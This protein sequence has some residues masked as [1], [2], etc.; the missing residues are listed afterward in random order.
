MINL[1]KTQELIVDRLAS[2][3]AYLKSTKDNDDESVLL[4]MKEVEEGVEIGDKIKVFV[5]RDSKDRIIAT[6]KKPKLT[7]GDIGLLEVVD[8]TNIG[9]FMDWGLEKD[10]FIPFKEQRGKIKKGREYLVGTYIDKS[11]R[12][13]ATMNVYDMLDTNSP[14]KEDD[15]VEGMV[16]NINP[17]IGIFVAV[18][19]KYHGLIPKQRLFRSFEL[20][21]KIEAKVIKVRKDGKL[22]LTIRKK[23]YKQI[24][25][26]ADRILSKLKSNDGVLMI[27]DKSAPGKIQRELKMSKASFK[28]AVGKLL[29]ENKIKFIEGGIKRL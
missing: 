10:L 20:G 8:T 5:Y 15:K 18:D 23:A 11:D 7:L 1:G 13:C 19:N 17:E 3:G 21:E 27:N 16:Y 28:R 6:T 25:G 12:L 14:Y 2:Q 22:E 4:P 9:A 29:K 24:D 26:D